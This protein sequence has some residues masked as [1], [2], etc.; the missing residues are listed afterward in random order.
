MH[1]DEWKRR[2]RGRLTLTVF[3]VGLGTALVAGS[4][5]DETCDVLV[6]GGGAAGI[7]A[8]GEAG[9]AGAKVIL[10]EQG[11]QVGGNMTSGGV[12]CPGLF[13]AYGEQVISGFGWEVVSNAMVLAGTKFPDVSKWRTAR[14]W[15]L[16]HKIS[17]P[18]FVALAEE[19]LDRA[20]VKIEYFSSAAGLERIG[21]SWK[22]KI[23]AGP[24][25]RLIT[26]K[27]VIDCTGAGSVAA[28]AGA[29]LMRSSERSPGTFRYVAKGVPPRSKWDVPAMQRA[30]KAAIADG[31]LQVGDTRDPIFGF[32]LFASL[33]TNYVPEADWSNADRRTASD[34]E[35]RA[36]MLRLYRFLRRQSGFENFEIVSCAAETG[37]RETA[38]VV[39]DYVL[40]VD[41]YVGGR[42]FDDA[43][44]HAFYPVDLHS[45]EAGVDPKYL[46]DGVKPTVPY[47]SLLP[48]GVDGMLVAGRCLSADR[49]AMAA[50]RVQASCMATGQA[51]GEAAA[52]AVQRGVDL[53]Q[54]DVGELKTRL[55][56]RGAIVP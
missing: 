30:Y 15:Q 22:V 28:M 10:V 55:R 17:I 34:K 18:L 48:K 46:K 26:A 27:V 2:A 4:L 49:M 16:Q 42:A 20:G 25:V 19:A 38:R 13:F 5:P 12:D 54:I 14:H 41:D 23:H 39:G 33:L 47:R 52:L 45:T 35:G 37:V 7:G 44:C 43:V 24:D 21:K 6:V 8:A 3:F 29:K 40:T 50:L 53:R 36:R 51:A 9:R 56:G 32:K 31:S 1:L 11:F